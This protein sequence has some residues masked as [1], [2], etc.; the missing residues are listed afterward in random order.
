MRGDP[1]LLCSGAPELLP[2]WTG[3]PFNYLIVIEAGR[4]RSKS[5]WL[6]RTPLTGGMA[7]EKETPT[8]RICRQGTGKCTPGLRKT[9]VRTDPRCRLYGEVARQPSGT[10]RSSVGLTTEN[11]VKY[12]CG[13]IRPY[14]GGAWRALIDEFTENKFTWLTPRSGDRPSRDDRAQP[15]KHQ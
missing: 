3:E 12:R 9:H 8:C 4:T 5:S 10:A 15:S 1:T 14:D 11:Y 6:D 2:R 13:G 7:A